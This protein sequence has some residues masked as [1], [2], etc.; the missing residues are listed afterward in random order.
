MS[1]F[2]LSKVS[3]IVRKA[4]NLLFAVLLVFTFILVIIMVFT[5]ISGKTPQ[6]FGYQILRISSSSMEPELNVGDIILSKRVDPYTL[7]DGDII[8]YHGEY[9]SYQGKLITHAVVGEP[10]EQGGTL[11]LKTM[12]IANGYVD[13]EISAEQVVGKMACKIPLLGDVYN[14]FITPYGLF[15]I[16]VFL[17]IFFINELFSLVKLTKRKEQIHDDKETSLKND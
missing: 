1:G 17:A 3:S 2:K 5:R 13:P 9:G 15:T 6:L 7:T 12:G 14:F 11:Y 16:L 10:A 8:T 4:L